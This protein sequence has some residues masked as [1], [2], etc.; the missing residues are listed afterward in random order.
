MKKKRV[1]SKISHNN[2]LPKNR[3]GMSS[4]VTTL[5]IIL[6]SIVALGIVWVVVKNII[7][8]GEEDISFTGITLNLEIQKASIS[9]NSLYVIVHRNAGEGTLVGINFVIGDGDNSVIIRRNTNLPQLGTQTFIFSI[10]NELSTLTEIKTISIAPIYET[11]A[12][13]EKVGEITDTLDSIGTGVIGGGGDGDGG[14]GGE[15]IECGNGKQEL[16]E[17][18][19]D[20][21]TAD[22]DGCSAI[23]EHEEGGGSYCGDETCDA[24][25]TPGNCPEDC[26]V[27]DSCNG[28]WNPPE[29]A[30]VECDGTPKCEPD[31]ICSVGFSEDGTGGCILKPALDTGIIFSV[32][33]NI[34]FDSNNL[35]KSDAVNAYISAY[36]NFSDSAE[37]SCFLI[38]FADYINENDISYL[39][40]DDSLGAPNINPDKGYSIWE[41]ENC[42]Q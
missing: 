25:E 16:G 6:L 9:G 37:V 38:T 23:C 42:G 24:T 20:G 35:P 30:R 31:C 39:R 22:G 19:D 12:G 13:K 27:P 11:S 40:V 28:V 26:A 17:E 8:K 4:V 7:S 29:D 1:K 14:D 10:K 32:W 15:G 36:V 21:N 41:A 5:L 34:Y 2:F 33:N 18:C 3:R